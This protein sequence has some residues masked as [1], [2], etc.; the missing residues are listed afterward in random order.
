MMITFHGSWGE[1]QR[2]FL[3][4]RELAITF[5]GNPDGLKRHKGFVRAVT[6]PRQSKTVEVID[7]PG[8]YESV[9]PVS[10]EVTFVF[11]PT[12]ETPR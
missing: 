9:G 7:E 12:K 8:Q 4:G 3:D 2:A 6:M 10:G 5:D 1:L 11:N